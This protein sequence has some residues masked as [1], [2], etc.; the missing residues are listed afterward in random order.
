MRL[1]QIEIQEI[2][3]CIKKYIPSFDLYLHGSRLENEKLGG[4]IDLFLVL[5]DSDFEEALAKKHYLL[6][7]IK[8]GL[9]DQKID[10]YLLS[11][12]K[13]QFDEFFL[14]SEKKLI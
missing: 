2:K 9:G 12:T 3:K 14:Q 1:S 10:M 8:M 11:K 13:S 7:S 6:A 5:D 4:D